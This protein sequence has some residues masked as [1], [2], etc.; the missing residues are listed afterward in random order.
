[1]ICFFFSGTHPP[2]KMPHWWFPRGNCVAVSQKWKGGQNS[3]F[4]F[5]PKLFGAR[6]W[7]NRNSMTWIHFILFHSGETTFICCLWLN[8][9]S[10][11]LW[12]LLKPMIVAASRLQHPLNINFVHGF[13]W[14]SPKKMDRSPRLHILS[15][16]SIEHFG[17]V[18]RSQAPPQLRVSLQWLYILQ[19][20]TVVSYRIIVLKHTEYMELQWIIWSHL[21]TYRNPVSTN[22]GMTIP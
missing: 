5:H 14:Q 6:S 21:E 11:N 20:S 16:E 7:H 17:P 1:M 15:V 3:A 18:P 12:N 13:W 4:R 22:E 19:I 9:F 10:A 8:I 2:W